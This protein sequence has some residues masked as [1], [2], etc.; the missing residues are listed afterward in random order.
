M[1]EAGL[2]CAPA[3]ILFLSIAALAYALLPRAS[4]AVAFAVVT[5]SFVWQLL[6]SIVGA[7]RWL[8]E[9]SPFE[10]VG[11][12]PAQPLKAGAAA[13]MLAVALLVAA[14]AVWAFSRRDLVGT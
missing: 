6:S 5:V 1:I 2:N 10:H 4:T 13:V 3:A 9:L 12:V 14:V 8:R 7:P 11:L